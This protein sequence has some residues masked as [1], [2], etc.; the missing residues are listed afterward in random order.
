MTTET[1][2]PA[3]TVPEEPTPDEGEDEGNDPITEDEAP[4]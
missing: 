4:E 1:T 3:P 2:P